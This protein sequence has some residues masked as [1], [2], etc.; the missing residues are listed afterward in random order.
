MN[1]VYK[2]IER[3]DIKSKYIIA[4]V[5]GGPDSM[6]MLSIL[7]NER[8]KL[9]KEIVV[10]HVHHNIRPESDYEAHELENYCKNNN[11]IFEMMKIDKYPNNKFSEESARII[12]YNFFDSIIKKYNSDI[13]FTAHHGDDLIE[14]ILMRLT[15]GSTIKGYAGFEPISTDRGYIIARPLVFLTKD[16]IENEIKNLGIWYAIDLSNK[17][18]KFKRNRF[19]NKIL[20]VLKHE[21]SNVNTKFLEYSNKMILIDK[22]LKK[23]VE[24]IKKEVIVNN[25]INICLFNKLD[26]IIK[27]YVLEDYLKSIYKSDI[28]AISNVHT[29]MI[30]NFINEINTSFSLPLNKQGIV[31]YNNFKIIDKLEENYYDIKFTDKV[32]V[33]N[34]KTIEIDNSTNDTSNYVIHLNSSD[35]ALPF[36]VRCKKPGDFMYIK[37][38]KGKK[39][40][41]NIFT[42]SKVSKEIRNTY[43]I[44]T[45]NENKIIWIPGIKKSNLDRKKD[46]KCDIILKYH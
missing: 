27:I 35:V 28:T 33:P 39:S 44:V 42:D 38:M 24:S 15:R 36:H 12:R 10:A 3:L 30:L 21:N 46:K 7:L 1:E 16:Q 23:Q 18:D 2:F 22:Y 37:N 8:T 31:E 17:T 19:R 13:L 45:D 9:N 41:S 14:T 4:A 26:E 6:L 32:E 40:I 34:G 43:P 11:I 20:P 25:S 5:S 29:N